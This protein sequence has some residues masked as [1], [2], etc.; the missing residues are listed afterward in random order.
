MS[1]SE[2]PIPDKASELSIS[3]HGNDT[4]FRHY[5]VIRDY[6]TSLVQR[7]G[8]EKF[9]SYGTT[10]ELAEKVGKQWRLVLRKETETGEED[11]WSEEWFDAVIVAN[12]HYNVPYI[13]GIPGLKEFEE[14]KPGSVKHTKMFRGKDAYKNKVRPSLMLQKKPDERRS[15]C[16]AIEL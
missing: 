12:G 11:E 5:S 8:Y 15:A 9:V 10:V 14:Q 1:F 4:P 6:I 16:R 2:E 7:N 3:K 13:P